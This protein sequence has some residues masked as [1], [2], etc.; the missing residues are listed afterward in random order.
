[1]ASKNWADI[2]DNIEDEKSGGLTSQ[3]TQLGVSTVPVPS[4]QSLPTP[5]VNTQGVD[6]SSSSGGGVG[7]GGTDL[8]GGSLAPQP[9]QPELPPLGDITEASIREKPMVSRR[10]VFYLDGN[11]VDSYDPR[12]KK[13]WKVPYSLLIS[14]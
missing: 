9:P 14:A 8:P 6:V 12:L 3:M 2:C 10:E 11:P 4:T 1:M 7:G 5:P 13:S